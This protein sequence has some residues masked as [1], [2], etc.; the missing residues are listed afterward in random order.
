MTRSRTWVV[1]ALV[2]TAGAFAGTV[3]SIR[4][5]PEAFEQSQPVAAKIRE[6]NTAVV[7]RPPTP[8]FDPV[9]RSCAHCHQI[10]R[11]ARSSSGPVLTGIIGRKAGS[12]DYA[13]SRAMRETDVIWTEDNLRAF[14]KG[15]QSVVPG[16][17]MA[18]GGLQDPQIDKL[19]EFLKESAKE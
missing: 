8:A 17:R 5:N 16:T 7:A 18:F 15:P 2:A 9:F 13:Y 4:T 10:G 1:L 19:M 3:M 6:G 11:N 12:T 14:L